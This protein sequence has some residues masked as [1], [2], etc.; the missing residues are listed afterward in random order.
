MGHRHEGAPTCL[1]FA[2]VRCRLAARG[3]KPPVGDL[4][5]TLLT[6]SEHDAFRRGFTGIESLS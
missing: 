2:S 4:E 5:V 1:S 3:D 6:R